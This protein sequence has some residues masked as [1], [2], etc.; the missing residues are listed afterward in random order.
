MKFEHLLSDI[1]GFGRFQ[2]MIIIISFVARFTLP[3]HFMLGNFIAAVPSH[4]CD[5]STLDD[6]G[7]FENL[8]QEQRL[9]VTI[10]VQED[11]TPSSCKMFPEPQFHLLSNSNGSDLATV[12]C[13]NG[14]VY[15]NSTFKSTL[16]TEWDLVCD[17]KGKNK[18]TATIFF[19]GVMFGAMTFGSL[20]DRWIPESARWLIANGKFEK[21]NF[22]LQQCAQINQKQE[23]ASKITP[24]TLSSIIVTERK[25]RTY[26]YLDLVRTPKMRR[27][28][29]LTGIV[30]YGVASTYYGISFNITGF[31][32]NIY[33]TQFVY[34]AIELPVTLSVYYLLD[35]VG[36]RNT[37]V[38]S[39]LGAGI[40]LAINIFLPRDMFVLR[41]V[42]AMLGKG[43]SAASFTTVVL[44]SSELFPTVVRQNGMGYNSSMGR[45]G[46]SLAPLIL[47]LDEVWR[48]LPQ[49]LLCSIALLASLVAR[50][51]PETRDRCLPET[52]QDIEDGQ[53][54]KSLAGSQV[55][56]TTEIPL[57]SKANDEGEN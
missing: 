25:D 45:L 32:L 28:A 12:P 56:E 18:A 13:Q 50:M 20:S 39:L 48:D 8:T 41:T 54:G 5:L 26:S 11:G 36:R 17:Q 42:V 14:W 53:T 2:I 6:E 55:V 22:Y 46:V 35:K 49:V 38:G 21:A 29:L 24:E 43:C 16:A 15:D 40:C 19:L 7:I 47:L 9:T 30:W 57:K 51:L 37:E 34:G 27:L 23:F 1:N 44:Y 10:P 31:G 4:R 3:C 52:I 33:L